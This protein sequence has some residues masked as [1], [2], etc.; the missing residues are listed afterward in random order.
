M[1]SLED[2]ASEITMLICVPFILLTLD[3][4]GYAYEDKIDIKGEIDVVNNEAENLAD[5]MTEL[6]KKIE[7]EGEEIFQNEEL[8]KEL[9]DKIEDL[10]KATEEENLIKLSETV[11]D[12]RIQE[13]KYQNRLT[14]LQYLAEKLE[15]AS[16]SSKT[17]NKFEKETEMFGILGSARQ[18][19]LKQI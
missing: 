12:R 8:Y 9:V 7:I 10:A 14:N 17:N 6:L 15:K 1:G 5:E 18:T 19:Y 3:S 4:F 2:T 13:E 11:K 16:L